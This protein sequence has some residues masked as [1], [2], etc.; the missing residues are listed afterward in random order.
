MGTASY[1]K[2]FVQFLDADGAKKVSRQLGACSV[3]E[4][5][6]LRASA[7][8][9]ASQRRRI[10]ILNL[11]TCMSFHGHQRHLTCA[12]H[13]H[14]PLHRPARRSTAACLLGARW[15][16]FSCSPRISWTQ[17]LRLRRPLLLPRRQ[18]RRRQPR[19]RRPCPRM[20]LTLCRR[21]RSD[22]MRRI[23]LLKQLVKQRGSEQLAR[24]ACVIEW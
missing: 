5:A 6:F 4:V 2:A 20:L 14:T 1:G 11:G 12:T 8:A 21:W 16:Q 13:G 3:S 24:L 17:L 22:G 15:K 9:A 10:L 7:W 18:P 19:R 23:G